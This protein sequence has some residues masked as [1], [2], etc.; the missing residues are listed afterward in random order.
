MATEGMDEF[1]QAILDAVYD[2]AVGHQK[3]VEVNLGGKTRSLA[4]T[5]SYLQ[6]IR[7]NEARK[8]GVIAIF[9]NITEIKE[10]REAE[11]RLAKVAK[12]QHAEL[13]QGRISTS[14]RRTRR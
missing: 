6:D 7:N 11:L 8:I 10:L 3:A 13:R 2:T 12:A 9:S 14:R 4:L 5:T 1:N